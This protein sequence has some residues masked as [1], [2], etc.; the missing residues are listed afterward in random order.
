MITALNSGLY[1]VQSKLPPVVKRITAGGPTSVSHGYAI[2]HR[3]RIFLKFSR[4]QRHS[5]FSR[6]SIDNRLSKNF[7]VSHQM[8]RI[9]TNDFLQIG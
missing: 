8:M 9:L 3:D 1:S 2:V 7:N 5:F 6:S 4:V